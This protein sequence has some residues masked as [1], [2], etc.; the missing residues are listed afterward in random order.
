MLNNA[1]PAA[2]SFDGKSFY[3]VS[4][5]NKFE[6]LYSCSPPLVSLATGSNFQFEKQFVTSDANSMFHD[7]VLQFQVTNS[8]ADDCVFYNLYDIISSIKLIINNEEIEHIQTQSDMIARLSEVLGK[9]KNIWNSTTKFRN[10]TT[11]SISTGEVFTNSATSYH[12]LSMFN[13]FPYLRNFALVNG[14]NSMRI[15]VQL[16][17]SAGLENLKF[18][19][20]STVNDAY[21]SNLTLSNIEMKLVYSKVSDGRLFKTVNPVMIVPKT[22][23]K[24]FL[25]KSWNVPDSDN[26]VINFFNDYT[27]FLTGVRGLSV[28]L[29]DNSTA[30]AY[31]SASAAKYQ[32][33]PDIFGFEL[34][35]GSNV[36]ID[37]KHSGKHHLQARKRYMSDTFENRHAQLMLEEHLNKTSNLDEYFMRN[38]TYID[39]SNVQEDDE[40]PSYALSGRPNSDSDLELTLWC[41]SAVSTNVNIY[42]VLHYDEIMS[43]DPRNGI[44]KLSL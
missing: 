20:S 8:A 43:I 19:Q 33:G 2:H 31:N 11:H 10:E 21:G 17:T 24:R 4:P 18:C 9:E 32:S 40:S 37:L 36:L 35:S 41:A 23:T 42:C 34:K 1:Q 22:I 26:L 25:S 14:I 12:Q 7:M 27:R 3:I 13:V 15:E 28:F 38:S 5:S 30:T 6:S 16:Q 29:Y 44:R 39:L